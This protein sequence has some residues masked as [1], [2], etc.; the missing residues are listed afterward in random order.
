MC[1][2]LGMGKLLDIA[3]HLP[4]TWTSKIRLI[5]AVTDYL[6]RTPLEKRLTAAVRKGRANRLVEL[7]DKGGWGIDQALEADPR[8]TTAWS[9]L[10]HENHTLLHL[11]A[12]HGQAQ[13]AEA[14][15][16]RGSTVDAT[17]SWGRTPAMYAAMHGD[18]ETL[19]ALELHGANLLKTL[20]SNSTFYHP[21]YV[22]PT[23][24]ELFEQAVGK[25]YGEAKAQAKAD[26]MDAVL[27]AATAQKSTVLR[28]RM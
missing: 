1:D 9:K 20:P 2:T 7:L 10:T 15:L 17:T 22:G 6:L 27:D 25:P 12:R 23:C 5:D 24:L 13:C 3:H 16:E 14:L 26:R 4:I 8:D 11:A 28:G 21:D 18:L 19:E